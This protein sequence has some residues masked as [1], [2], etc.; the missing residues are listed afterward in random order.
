MQ[1]AKNISKMVRTIIRYRKGIRR[2]IGA[3]YILSFG[4][5]AYRMMNNHHHKA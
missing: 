4:F 5:R 3:F 1:R 2:M